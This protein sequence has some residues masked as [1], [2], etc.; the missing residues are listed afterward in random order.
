MTMKNIW[1]HKARSFKEA[2]EFEDKYYLLKTP[3]ER[4]S[5]MQFCR[6][7]YFK[8]KGIVDEGGKGLRRVIRI[9]KQK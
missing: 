1:L 8:I 9:F 2:K 4:L 5:D 6:D 3:S 7:Q